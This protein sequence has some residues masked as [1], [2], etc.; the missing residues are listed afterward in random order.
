M[1]TPNCQNHIGANSNLDTLTESSNLQLE[2]ILILH[3][4][5]EYSNLWLEPIL[6]LHIANRYKSGGPPICTLLY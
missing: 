4:P 6:N 1:H 2:P 5:S 3:T